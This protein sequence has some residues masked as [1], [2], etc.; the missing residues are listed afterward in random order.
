MSWFKD[1]VGTVIAKSRAH[2]S[3][4]WRLLDVNIAHPAA[5]FVF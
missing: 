5:G 2:L 1:K 4:S 3:I